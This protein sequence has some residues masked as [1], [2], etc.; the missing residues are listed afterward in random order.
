MLNY[1]SVK[2]KEYFSNELNGS[3]LIKNYLV[4]LNVPCE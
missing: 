4:K 2:S 3:E 1:I